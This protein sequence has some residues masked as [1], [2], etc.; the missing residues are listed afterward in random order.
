M[1]KMGLQ[2]I[3]L[4]AHTNVFTSGKYI[5]PTPDITVSAELLLLK[6]AGMCKLQ[7]L[8][9]VKAWQ[10][11]AADQFK[12]VFFS[13]IVGRNCLLSFVWKLLTCEFQFHSSFVRGKLI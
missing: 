9:R 5:L 10:K 7:Y 1:V 4:K 12:V 3:L 6:W 11:A 13:T 2:W 8:R